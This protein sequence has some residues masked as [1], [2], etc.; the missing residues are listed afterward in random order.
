MIF[1]FLFSLYHSHNFSGA[2][3]NTQCFIL[4]H[5]QI[6]AKAIAINK[7]LLL[8]VVRKQDFF[9]YFRHPLCVYVLK[10]FLLFLF[11]AQHSQIGCSSRT[12]FFQSFCNC[13]VVIWH[14][15]TVQLFAVPFFHFVLMI[16]VCLGNVLLLYV[17]D[18]QIY[19][20]E[21]ELF[22]ERARFCCIS[23]FNLLPFS[24]I[25]FVLFVFQRIQSYFSSPSWDFSTYNGAIL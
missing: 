17:A 12:I 9:L 24:V 7:N 20:I 2:F 16:F 15:E 3:A 10:F 11:C 6:R 13:I 8:I 21:A 5:F 25:V 4:L 14:C 23:I 1:L 19:T 22:L 18:T